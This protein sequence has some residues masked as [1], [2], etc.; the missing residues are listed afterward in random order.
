[1]ACSYLSLPIPSI[2]PQARVLQYGDWVFIKDDG[3]VRGEGVQ[4]A[5]GGDKLGLMQALWDRGTSF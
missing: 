2:Y 4:M 3:M 1:M 5:F